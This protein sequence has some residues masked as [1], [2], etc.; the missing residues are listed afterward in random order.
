[1]SVASR[2][3]DN[4]DDPGP[5]DGESRAGDNEDWM[6]RARCFDCSRTLLMGV[7]NVTPD[8][9]S[10]GGRYLDRQ[11]AVER[12]L[13]MIAEGA[14]LVDVG[15]E[16]TRPGADPVD[17][18]TELGRV[19]PVVESLSAATEVPISIDTQKA[20]VAK[21]CLQAGAV[22]LN[23]V[24]GLR[25][26]AMLAVAAETGASVVVMHMRGT[27]PTMQRDTA[28]RDVV[29]EVRD[30]LESQASDAE[31]AGIEEL[32]VDPGLGFGKSPRQNFEILARLP[33]IVEVG[34]PVLIGPSR[35]S[36]LGSLPS[37]L[38][39]QERVEGTLAAVAVAVM[40]GAKLVRVHDVR[41]CR[42]V[43]D[44]L[45]AVREVSVAG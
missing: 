16:S 12:G 41:Q 17:E 34:Y 22:V 23:D 29:A 33:E 28:Y 40:N 6:R 13:Q 30:Y 21:R 44:V 4:R 3:K 38:P 27:P 11:R 45:D 7:L 32:A 20:T 43:L 2:S 15:G 14:D 8:S 26:P 35:K 39:T 1:M 18:C 36:F 31:R 5:V 37:R 24:G 42:R 19:L 10:D 9:F 25:D